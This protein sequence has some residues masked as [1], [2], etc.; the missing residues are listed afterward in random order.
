MT[1]TYVDK[2]HVDTYDN[3]ERCHV[4]A[5]API[6]VSSCQP[7][8]STTANVDV[9]YERQGHVIT[10]SRRERGD[11]VGAPMAATDEEGGQAAGS[12]P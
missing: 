11:V 8:E 12:N 10:M 3:P 4:I 9:I 1:P 2:R 6:Y 5:E 7:A